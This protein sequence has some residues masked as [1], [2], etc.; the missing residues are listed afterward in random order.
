VMLL[1]AIC[2]EDGCLVWRQESQRTGGRLFLAVNKRARW[3]RAGS[4]L[5]YRNK[6]VE[7]QM[8]GQRNSNCR[9]V[10][11]TCRQ[12]WQSLLRRKN[13][14]RLL[15]WY[16]RKKNTQVM[17]LPRQSSVEVQWYSRRELLHRNDTSFVHWK[18]PT[19]R[20]VK[21]YSLFQGQEQIRKLQ[22]VW[23]RWQ[24]N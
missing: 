24:G 6:K 3:S 22:E 23:H 7:F 11:L 18:L 4:R 2:C 10:V 1:Y 8:S 21:L 16:Q 5:W 19:M 14:V 15:I 12:T 17:C 20:R 9:D 13:W